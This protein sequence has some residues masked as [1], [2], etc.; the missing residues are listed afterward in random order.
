LALFEETEE[1]EVNDDDVNW[2]VP[3]FDVYSTY[4]ISR[5]ATFFLWSLVSPAPCLRASPLR[6]GVDESNGF[7]RTVITMRYVEKI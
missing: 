5:V 1:T 3:F 2:P 6:G 4:I 7:S